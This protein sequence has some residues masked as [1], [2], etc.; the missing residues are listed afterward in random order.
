VV[1]IAG[2]SGDGRE[3]TL[4]T[5][6]KD[7]HS[8]TSSFCK[9]ANENPTAFTKY[10]Q[11][12]PGAFILLAADAGLRLGELRGLRWQD[13]SFKAATVRVMV[14]DWNG[15]VG[16]PKSGKDR[17]VP[18]TKR[19]VIA[20]KAIQHL[21][22]KL[23]IAPWNVTD[24]SSYTETSMH[25]ALKRQL[26]RAKLPIKGQTGRNRLWHALRHTFCSNLAQAG[27]PAKAIQ[28]L[29]GH[30]SIAVTN[31]YMHATPATLAAAMALLEQA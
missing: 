19:L 2:V 13:I 15:E 27:A 29:A 3:C 21:R 16:A 30:Q 24:G 8:Q 23:V 20:L 18:L 9:F 17:V 22:S 14:S 5:I 10:L 4:Q 26:K 12:R 6:R 28:E 11:R 1:C 31:R 7:K 25:A